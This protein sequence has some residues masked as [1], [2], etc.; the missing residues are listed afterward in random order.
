MVACEGPVGLG[1]TTAVTAHLLRRAIKNG[2]RH[3]II[4]APYTNIISQTAKVLRRALTLSGESPEEVV[5]EHHHRADFSGRA[6]RELAVLWRAP[7]IL[8][9]AVQFFETLASNHPGQ[10]RK[11]HELPGSGIFLDEAHAALP[12]RLWP[13][14]L[15][16]AA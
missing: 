15:A 13:Q 3:L 6:D 8:T 14:N 10:L 9:T 5:A 1:K 7:V 2:L 12:A 4:V 11:L 16:L